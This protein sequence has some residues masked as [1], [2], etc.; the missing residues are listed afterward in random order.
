MSSPCLTALCPCPFSV[1]DI[2]SLAERETLSKK[3]RKEYIEA[4]KCLWASPSVDPEFSAAQNHFDDYVAVH[5]NQTNTIHGTANFLPWHRYLIYLWEQKLRTQCGYNGY[6]PVCH[7][8][9][10]LL[11]NDANCRS[12]GTGSNTRTTCPSRPFLTAVTPVWAV[13]ASSSP[14]TGVWWEL[15]VSGFH[16]ERAAVV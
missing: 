8:S 3:E 9:T 5:M 2:F 12:I 1:A 6:L 13:M 14:I 11:G 15:G 4:V 7:C 16:L 10:P